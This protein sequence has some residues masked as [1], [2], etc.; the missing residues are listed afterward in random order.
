MA[1]ALAPQEA[2][3]LYN[4]ACVYA[5]TGK[6]DRAIEYLERAVDAGYSHKSWLENDSDFDSIREDERFKAV[7]ERI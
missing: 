3:L 4:A 7:L 6:H 2:G 5:T 1:V